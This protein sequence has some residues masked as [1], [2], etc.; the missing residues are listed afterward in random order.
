MYVTFYTN[1]RQSV[2]GPYYEV[3]ASPYSIEVRKTEDETSVTIAMLTKGDHQG[4]T[5]VG[6]DGTFELATGGYITA[7]LPKRY[8]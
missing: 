2:L 8:K 4:W 1:G 5:I 7:F 6:D 3:V